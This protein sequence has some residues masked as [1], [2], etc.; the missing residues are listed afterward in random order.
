MFC[1]VTLC[2]AGCGTAPAV[3]TWPIAIVPCPD[4]ACFIPYFKSCGSA[5]VKVKFVWNTDYFIRSIGLENNKC[6]YTT[7]ITDT[8]GAVVPSMPSKDCLMPKG[9][10]TDALFG[11]LFGN[12]KA[13]GQEKVLAAMTKL[14]TENC[15]TK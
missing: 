13:A 2:L 8:S 3:K 11:H 10:M 6:H 14:E 5:Q 1:T 12:D 4:V 9:Q 7:E 15:T